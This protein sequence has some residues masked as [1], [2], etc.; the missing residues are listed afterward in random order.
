MIKSNKNMTRVTSINILFNE[1]IQS[2][3]ILI[4]SIKVAF[5]EKNE[6]I[7]LFRDY[8]LP[9]NPLLRSNRHQKKGMM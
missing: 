3:F 4:I 6:T 5:R 7:R 9:G 8:S 1:T 2:F